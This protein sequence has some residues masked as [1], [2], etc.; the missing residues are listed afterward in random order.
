MLCSSLPDGQILR[1]AYLGSG[2][3]LAHLAPGAVIVDFSTTEPAAIQALHE[4]LTRLEASNAALETA[5]RELT[6]RIDRRG[7]R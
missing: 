7:R 1:D 2:A 3:V 5:N 6:A 4:R